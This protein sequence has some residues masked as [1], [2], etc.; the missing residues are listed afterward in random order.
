MTD[1]KYK[2]LSK[3]ELDYAMENLSFKKEP[4]WHQKVSLAFAVGRSRI[5][6]FHGIGTGKTPSAL[7]TAQMWE[8]NR[9]LVVCPISAINAWVTLTPEFSDFDLNVID[10]TRDN[11]R[12]KLNEDK[13][14]CVINYEGLKSVYGTMQK[15]QSSGKRSWGIDLSKFVDKFDCI[16]FDEIHR[17][18]NYKSLQSRICFE[19]SRRSKTVIGLSGTPVDKSLLDL[20]NIYQV[21]DL[22]RT[23]GNSFFLYRNKYFYKAGFNWKTKNGKRDEILSKLSDS[24][25]CFTR[26]ECTDLPEL[27]EVDLWL[28]PD[29]E[30]LNLQ[31]AIVEDDSTSDGKKVS[32]LRQIPSGFVYK[33]DGYKDGYTQLK[34]TKLDALIEIIKDIDLPI[35]VFYHYRATYEMISSLLKREKIKS[36]CAI[37]GQNPNDRQEEINK[38]KSG[39][40]KVMLAHQNC[41][42]EGFDATIAKTL[43]FFS[44]V[45]SPKIR[46]QCIGRIWR[47]G[48]TEKSLV[49]NL[50]LR[51][52][53]DWVAIKSRNDRTSMVKEVTSFIRGY[54]K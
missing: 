22:G 11:R 33:G 3:E 9:I 42:S 20:F 21:L 13:N 45:A 32:A 54:H 49:I 46:S 26:D 12:R 6:Y 36:V 34:S 30:F 5:A 27:Q 50:L 15:D 24:T 35:I 10:G 47:S 25:I 2:S 28:N 8:R 29:S 52:S 17:C 18:S 51:K 4:R 53:T 40:F 7:F 19:L 16:I 31:K 48:Q 44:T 14:V 43:V 1:L 38:F 39:K 23:L 37:G 41:A